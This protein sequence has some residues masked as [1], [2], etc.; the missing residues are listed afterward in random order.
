MAVKRDPVNRQEAYAALLARDDLPRTVYIGIDP[1]M[2]GA[3]AVLRGR[4]AAV[5]DMPTIE[6]RRNIGK[7]K[8]KKRREFDDAAIVELFDDIRRAELEVA[9][10]TLEHAQVVVIDRSR[11]K[12]KGGDG[13][14]TGGNG[15]GKGKGGDG[16]KTGGNTA[17]TAFVVGCGFRMWHL[18]F[19]CLGWPLRVVHPATWKAFM[20][21]TG[22]GKPGSIKMANDLYPELRF[23]L[24]GDDG[25]AEAVLL[26]RYGAANAVTTGEDTDGGPT[27]DAS[28]E[29]GAAEVTE[30]GEPESESAPGGLDDDGFA[31]VSDSEIAA[32]G[33][34]LDVDSRFDDGFEPG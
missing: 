24:S 9:G 3:I 2:S 29:A 27:D 33:A 13:P 32:I 26:A 18:Y 21:L 23:V 7:G 31:A 28:D 22:A 10:V 17:R 30:P 5:V 16:S 34:T 12:G 20:K 1:G 14:K 8:N 25:R 4:E 11:G 15:K 19:R 6:L